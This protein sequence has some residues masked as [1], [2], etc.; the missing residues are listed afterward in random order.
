MK[1]IFPIS[2]IFFL[3]F[4]KSSCSLPQ[5]IIKT[6][7]AIDVIFFSQQNWTLVPIMILQKNEGKNE[8][9]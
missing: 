3:S 6:K 5:F 2:H 4:F 1:M 8:I 7:V 9:K